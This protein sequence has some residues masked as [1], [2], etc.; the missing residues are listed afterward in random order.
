MKKLSPTTTL[1]VDRLI[2]V[3]SK[4]CAIVGSGCVLTLTL[5]VELH[6]VQVDCEYVIDAVGDGIGELVGQERRFTALLDLH[7]AVAG[8]D[9]GP[10]KSLA[11][12]VRWSS[13][14]LRFRCPSGDNRGGR[15]ELRDRGIWGRGA[16]KI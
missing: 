2:L 13:E 1:T 14:A 11:A 5:D 3:V 4:T 15:R 16:E 7:L 8:L 6:F 9:R 10:P 12:T